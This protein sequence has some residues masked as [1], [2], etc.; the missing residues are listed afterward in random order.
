VDTS[1]DEVEL[2]RISDDFAERLVGSLPGW[3]ERVATQR[4]FDATGRGPDEADRRSIAACCGHIADRVAP[5]VRDVVTA[6]VD[7]AAGSPLALLRE[8]VGPLNALLDELG[9]AHASRDRMAAELFPD[10]PHDLGPASFADIDPELVE[11]G[12]AW[13]AARAHV[14]LRRHAVAPAARVSTPVGSGAVPDRPTFDRILASVT[15]VE[16][17]MSDGQASLLHDR[18]RKLKPGDRIV[19]IGSFRG[20]S[21]IVLAKSAPDGVEIVA[22]D[23][24]GGGDRG[25]QEISPDQA[26][27]DDDNKAFNANLAAAGVAHRVTHIRKMSDDALDDVSGSIDLLYIDGAHR[28]GPARADIVA[29]G[30]RVDPGGTMLIHDSFSSI[31]VTLALLTTTLIGRRW[32]YMG[33]A[34]SMAEFRRVDLTGA[35][36]MGNAFRQLAQLPWFAR[37]VVIKV[38]ITVKLAP[39]TRLLGHRGSDWPY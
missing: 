25:P 38:L 7:S 39:L 14:H 33:R 29:W 31:G 9:V 4:M 6:D 35:A 12:V 3:L 26:L 23:P 24:H 27:G 16:G 2:C 32:R 17:W 5:L 22:I 18:A 19:E 21:M 15:D 28:F 20:R 30:N 10:D 13:G 36:R 1:D 34:R 11:F 8:A 37:N